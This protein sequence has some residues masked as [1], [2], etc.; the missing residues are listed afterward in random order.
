MQ[1]ALELEPLEMLVPPTPTRRSFGERL[2]RSAKIIVSI[3]LVVDILL[4]LATTTWSRLG[5][6]PTVQALDE[7][8]PLIPALESSPT[9]LARDACLAA[10]LT[11]AAGSV[12]WRFFLRQ[13]DA[14]R[15]FLRTWRTKLCAAAVDE[16]SF[17]TALHELLVP[18]RRAVDQHVHA[19]F[20]VKS[21]C[22]GT[23]ESILGTPSDSF[24]SATILS[25][26]PFN[27][28][29]GSLI[30]ALANKLMA[31]GPA[32]CNRAAPSNS[33]FQLTRLEAELVAAM[34]SHRY[35][36]GFSVLSDRWTR[37][38]ANEWAAADEGVRRQT[39]AYEARTERLMEAHLDGC[40]TLSEESGC[41]LSAEEMVASVGNDTE[42][43]LGAAK[44]AL[45]GL[46]TS[47]YGDR[48]GLLSE[49]T[50]AA[51]SEGQPPSTRPIRAALGRLKALP[52][53]EA[54]GKDWLSFFFGPCSSQW[55]GCMGAE[56]VPVDWL[57]TNLM[58]G[59][60][61]HKHTPLCGAPSL[62]RTFF[63]SEWMRCPRAARTQSHDGGAPRSRERAPIKHQL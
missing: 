57:Y 38:C 63:G 19:A 10:A 54:R 21:A 46:G 49:C 2:H 52:I 53:D 29:E 48:A 36:S 34:A 41:A 59:V 6:L 25:H 11:R 37:A 31:S 8:G 22:S 26:E 47:V 61:Y 24:C 51:E 20:F 3:F 58:L 40:C 30:V 62:A 44:H 18:L 45:E 9:P 39:A 33:A 60:V 50:L 16:I 32:A 35:H 42:L 17:Q 56:G 15:R 43:V 1:P 27:V 55:G 12:H 14:T 23:H 5:A 28:R 13:Q 7:E 4:I